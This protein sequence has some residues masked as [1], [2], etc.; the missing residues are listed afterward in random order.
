VY[1]VDGTLAFLG[2]AELICAL[3]TSQYE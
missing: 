3:L 1:G 2:V